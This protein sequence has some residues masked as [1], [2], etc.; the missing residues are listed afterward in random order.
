[1]PGLGLGIGSRVAHA[2]PLGSGIRQGVAMSDPIPALNGT[3]MIRV[4]FFGDPRSEFLYHHTDHEA[5]L[6][7]HELLDMS[8]PG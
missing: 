7:V 2:M 1:M 5:V 3:P 4:H 8:I 6:P